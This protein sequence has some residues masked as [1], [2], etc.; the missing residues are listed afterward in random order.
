MESLKLREETTIEVTAS[1]R[2]YTKLALEQSKRTGREWGSGRRPGPVPVTES[3]REAVNMAGSKTPSKAGFTA[4]S[5]PIPNRMRAWIQ[6]GS[7][8]VW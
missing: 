4:H 7:Q 8:R 5:M 1:V 2:Q 3:R 6:R